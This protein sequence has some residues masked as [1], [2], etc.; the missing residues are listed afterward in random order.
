MKI[1]QL[2]L[3]RTALILVAGLLCSGSYVSA[4]NSGMEL[5]ANAKATASDIGLPAYPGSSIYKDKDNDGAVDM[6]FSFGDSQFRLMAADYISSDAPDKILAF[7]RDPL[8]HYG[9]VLE[10]VDGKPVGALTVTRTGLT[11]SDQHGG[12]VQVNGHTD[13]K[14]HELRAGTPHKFRI[15]GIDKVQAN[16]TRFGLVYVQLPKDQD[17]S[18]KSK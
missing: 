17:T 15:V 16:S 12:N 14:G 5:H 7:Y 11:C 6:G 1:R 13:S 18:K 8:S 3:S 2:H 4:Q 9:E 10:C